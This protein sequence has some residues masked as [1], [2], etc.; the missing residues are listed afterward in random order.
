MQAHGQQIVD[1]LD[2][3]P[4]DKAWIGPGLR[5]TPAL[6]RPPAGDKPMASFI[7]S[8]E[9]RSDADENVL[10]T[11]NASTRRQDA[12]LKA[13]VIDYNKV[14]SVMDGRGHGLSL[15]HI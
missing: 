15:I 5:L 7:E 10:L 2:A 14:S 8:D 9:L 6:N 12:I 13:D 11:G 4:V 1:P 3:K